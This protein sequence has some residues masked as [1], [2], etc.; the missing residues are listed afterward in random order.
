[1]HVAILQK[2]VPELKNV[3]IVVLIRC[4]NI[5]RPICAKPQDQ[6]WRWWPKMIEVAVRHHIN[7][8]PA[9]P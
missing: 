9:H 5:F 6:Q 1:M 3:S 4:F 7:T 2:F 8:H